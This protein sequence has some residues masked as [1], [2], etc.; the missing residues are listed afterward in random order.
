MTTRLHTPSVTITHV[1]KMN[2][3]YSSPSVSGRV[4]VT[5]RS[6]AV[7]LVL[8]AAGS[9]WV[10][11]HQRREREHTRVSAGTATPEGGQYG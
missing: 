1:Y 6:A 3:S 4:N 10:I 2:L 7:S 9:W 8:C 11:V 5:D